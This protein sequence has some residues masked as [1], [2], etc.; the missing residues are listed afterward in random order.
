MYGSCRINKFIVLKISLVENCKFFL[1]K[2][3][4]ILFDLISI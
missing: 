1:L 2:E 4:M 3:I